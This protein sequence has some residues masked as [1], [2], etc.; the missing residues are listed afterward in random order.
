[1]ANKN[2]QNLVSTGGVSFTNSNVNL[3]PQ[4]LAPNNYLTIIWKDVKSNA[5]II[6]LDINDK[7]AIDY[8]NRLSNTIESAIQNN[9]F[10][11]LGQNRYINL[12]AI[13][14]YLA[15][16]VIPAG[17]KR[18]V[19][20][21]L[22]SVA[23]GSSERLDND[24]R[25]LLLNVFGTI[26][27]KT[28]RKLNLTDP[29]SI[30][31]QVAGE[32]VLNYLGTLANQIQEHFNDLFRKK[33]NDN[34]Q[35]TAQSNIQDIKTKHETKKYI[36]LLL[37]LT[38]SDTESYEITI[39]R[40]K[41]EDGSDYT[42]HLL[43][44]PFKKEFQVKLTNKILSDT[45]NQTTEINAIEFTKNKLIEIAKSHTLFDIYIRLNSEKIYKISN[46]CF[47]SLSFS[48][49]ENE[50]NGYNAS[51]TI[52]PVTSFKTKTVVSTKKFGT[53]SK[54]SGGT[55]GTSGSISRSRGKGSGGGKPISNLTNNGKK[56]NIKYSYWKQNK[57]IGTANSISQLQKMYP[58]YYVVQTNEANN[59]YQLKLKKSC[60]W[61]YDKKLNKVFTLNEY[62][63][64]VNSQNYKHYFSWA[65]TSNGVT[66]NK[67]KELFL[68]NGKKPMN[69]LAPSSYTKSGG[70]FPM[71]ILNGGVV[72]SKSGFWFKVIR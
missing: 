43:P 10:Q 40:K 15:Q 52:E 1:M 51:F 62:I 69:I 70:R 32:N 72:I 19:I 20:N 31:S 71:R 24:T 17:T 53:V 8:T 65:W 59:K 46:V 38:T 41:V 56:Q 55:G 48:K 39:P 66:S 9:S 3:K 30:F 63:T 34:N 25:N 2:N 67:Q 12:E 36:G 22:I 44:Q 57:L 26:A 6:T 5:V 64:Q 42:T 54:K 13:G 37:G 16:N 7:Q 29:T 60:S 14:K 68:K 47:S 45:F 58:D 49:D 27:D 11:Y 28:A 4:D 35:D 18:R 50:G 23:S 61:C 33:V 21:A